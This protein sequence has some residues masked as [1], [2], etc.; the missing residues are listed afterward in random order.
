MRVQFQKWQG[1]GNDFIL[2]DDRSLRLSRNL[3][4]IRLMCDRHF[5][6]G[7]DG[8][9]FIKP[10]DEYEM[11]FYNPD[12]SQSFCG[13][14][15]RCAFAFRSALLNDNSDVKFQAIDGEHTASWVDGLVN[16]SMRDVGPRER[17]AENIDLIDT[18]SPH[19]VVW[20]SEID[21]INL[22]ENARAFRYNERFSAQGVNVNFVEFRGDELFMRTYERGVES[23]TLSCG[24]GVTAAALSA[25][26]RT[27]A[28]RHIK[29]NT[30]G[31]VLE[32][33]VGDIREDAAQE[34]HLIGPAEF[35]FAGEIECP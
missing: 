4:W 30:P 35:V 26:W 6:I 5:G 27:G 24:T 29:V 31:G 25:L 21:E 34:I 14:G 23:E 9:I 11:D 10:G 3:D 33:S 28:D 7:S 2:I 12:G 16:L 15:S 20:G 17:L 1:A 18:G 32:V 19:L 22:I 8:L 13:N